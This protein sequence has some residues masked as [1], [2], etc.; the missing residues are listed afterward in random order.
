M[1]TAATM[2]QTVLVES[3]IKQVITLPETL[4]V[5]L[6][7]QVDSKVHGNRELSNKLSDCISEVRNIKQSTHNLRLRV[8]RLPNEL[9]LTVKSEIGLEKSSKDC[10]NIT[11]D[12]KESFSSIPVINHFWLKRKVNKINGLLDDCY[13]DSKAIYNSLQRYYKATDLEKN[14]YL[15]FESGSLKEYINSNSISVS[16]NDWQVLEN[17]LDKESELTAVQIRAQQ[18]YLSSKRS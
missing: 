17:E 5:V 1:T 18:R 8:E 15:A 3:I 7:E 4:R 2:E 12:L 10:L 9:T 16:V 11:K 6:A 14:T 13:E